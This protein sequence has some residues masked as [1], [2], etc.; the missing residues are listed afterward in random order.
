[1]GFFCGCGK[2]NYASGY[3]LSLNDDDDDDDDKGCMKCYC[4]KITYTFLEETKDE[5]ECAEYWK[6]LDDDY[7]E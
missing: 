7:N 6:E 4:G 2:L 1:M 5:Q 3:G